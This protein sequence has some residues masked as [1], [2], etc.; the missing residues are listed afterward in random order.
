VNDAM[1]EF[2]ETATAHMRRDVEAGGKWACACEAC[3]HVRALVGVEKVL[4]VRPL[5]RAIEQLEGQLDGLPA[6]PERQRLRDQYLK[7]HDQ[8][9]EVVAH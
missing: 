4:E 2:K 7:L 1:S 6:G 9:A 3:G 8:L 5:V